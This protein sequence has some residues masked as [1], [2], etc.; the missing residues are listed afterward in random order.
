MFFKFEH[1]N[2]DLFVVTVSGLVAQTPV[3]FSP[4]LYLLLTYD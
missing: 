1:H 3:K 4:H 2:C